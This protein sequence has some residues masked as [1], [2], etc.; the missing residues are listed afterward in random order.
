VPDE[1]TFDVIGYYLYTLNLI[2]MTDPSDR[3]T[4]R[5]LKSLIEKG[6]VPT[7]ADGVV[8]PFHAL[9]YNVMQTFE[10]VDW[11]EDLSSRSKCGWSK[12]ILDCFVILKGRKTFFW[13]PA[14][15]RP[16]K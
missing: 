15:W 13:A 4:L 9:L 16:I 3:Q 6:F 2:P 12:F 7:N 1:L 11:W 14:P 5:I 8:P 10:T